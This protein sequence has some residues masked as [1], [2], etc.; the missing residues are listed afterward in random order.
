VIQN[1]A[2]YV[3]Y[4]LLGL[5]PH[6]RL[7]ESINFFVYDTIKIII[8]L[9]VMIFIISIVRSFFPPERTRQLLS[10]YSLYTGH[11]AAAVLGTVTPF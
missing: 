11:A 6:T 9:S 2:D 1:F 4:T 5:T 3:V 8:L 7:G 10:G